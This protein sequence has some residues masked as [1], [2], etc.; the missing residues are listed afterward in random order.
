MWNNR[1]LRAKWYL[2]FN[3]PGLFVATHAYLCADSRQPEL[4]RHFTKFPLLYG[5]FCQAFFFLTVLLLWSYSHFRM[6]DFWD[7]QHASIDVAEI[8]VHWS[9]STIWQL[10]SSQAGRDTPI[11]LDSTLLLTY[12]RSVIHN[13]IIIWAKLSPYLSAWTRFF[14]QQ[15]LIDGSGL[16]N[17][18]P[19]ATNNS[20]PWVA[21]ICLACAV[22]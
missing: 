4:D 21:N 22:W 14:R 17:D 11:L 6:S 1:K 9:D 3:H 8:S 5:Y 13:C 19:N 16:V 2:K 7:L 10:S 12:C 20:A 15:K 18:N